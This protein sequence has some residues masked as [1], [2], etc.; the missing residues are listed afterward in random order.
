MKIVAT[1]GDINGIGLEVLL[2]AASRLGNSKHNIILD[3]ACNWKSIKEYI[4]KCLKT[5]S[6][7]ISS[8]EIK[9]GNFT[10]GI[11]NSCSYCKVEPG[12]ETAEAGRLAIQ[13]I[14]TA[15][16]LT[17]AGEYDAMVTMPISKHSAHLSG[18]GFP[19]HTE[20][21][22]EM[23]KTGNPLMILFSGKFRVALATVHVPLSKVH[24]LITPGLIDM[25]V[26]QFNNSLRIDFGLENP[27][28]AILGLNPHAGEG[29]DIGKE[30]IKVIEPSIMKLRD[31]GI[32]AEG[33]FPADGFFARR[34]YLNFDGVLAMYHD[35]GLIP[36]KL[37]AKG[38]VNFTAGLPIVRTSP[39]HGTAFA[40]AGK[41][42]ASEAGTL[43]AILSAE[44]I[45]N[46]RRRYYAKQKI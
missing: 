28:I 10:I 24:E 34:E 22:A 29:G 35:Q 37:M 31:L 39:D 1:I 26:K 44:K 46:A 20:M 43:N 19:G 6:I 14:E 25:K 42:L 16:R 5:D 41:G 21:L 2:K 27:R 17:E 12:R 36:L 40:I 18:F 33:P 8:K 9:A 7:S 11:I 38:G 15:Y 3:I 23:S 45:Y 13:S 32:D 30:E 4:K